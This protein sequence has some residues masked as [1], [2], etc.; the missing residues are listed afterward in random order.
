[1]KQKEKKGQRER[2][3]TETEKKANENGTHLSGRLTL[4][5]MTT[6]REKK[7]SKTQH[8]ESEAAKVRERPRGH[9]R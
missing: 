6:R 4:H 2:G 8:R 3:G 7:R 5:E 9:R 1:M